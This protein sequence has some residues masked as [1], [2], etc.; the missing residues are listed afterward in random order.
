[1]EAAPKIPTDS[2]VPMGYATVG[3]VS[4]KASAC[5]HVHAN[6]SPP[7]YSSIV[8]MVVEAIFYCAGTLLILENQRWMFVSSHRDTYPH[9]FFEAVY[10]SVITLTCIGCVVILRARVRHR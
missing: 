1:M 2:P 4:A 8:M 6:P 3:R 9:T 5:C 10:L 7:P